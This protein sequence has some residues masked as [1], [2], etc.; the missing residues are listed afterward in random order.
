MELSKPLKEAKKRVSDKVWDSICR[1][2]IL[3]TGMSTTKDPDFD[4]RG[5]KVVRNICPLELLENEVPEVPGGTGQLTYHGGVDDYVYNEVEHQ[6]NG[7]LARYWYP[8]YRKTHD[9]VR[10]QIEKEIKSPL[11]KT[12]YYDRFYY[13]GQDLEYHIDRDSCEISIT[14]HCGSNLRDDW[15]ICVKGVDGSVAEVNLKPGDGLIYKG[16]ERPHWRLPMPGVKRNI[17]RKLF[18]LDAYYYHQIFFHYVLKYGK[19][20]QFAGDHQAAGDVNYY[21]EG[22]RSKVVTF[23]TETS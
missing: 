8:F 9:F 2:E 19:R 12:Y 20:A 10:K 7:S 15:P 3:K 22:F 21:N 13:P 23:E 5:Y 16:C 17:I 11:C 14:I 4:N 6:V 1:N 18:G